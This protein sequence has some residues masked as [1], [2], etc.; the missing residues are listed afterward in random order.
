MPCSLPRR[1][2]Q[3][4]LELTAAVLTPPFQPTNARL[5]HLSTASS[6]AIT[7]ANADEGRRA[8]VPSRSSRW[9]LGGPHPLSPR[10]GWDSG[11]RRHDP[12]SPSRGMVRQGAAHKLVIHLPGQAAAREFLATD[13][14]R[15]PEDVRR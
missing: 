14:Y 6:Q 5:E 10:W 8:G 11:A 2:I 13:T 4:A 12:A 3:G 9:A 1:P 7:G 15:E